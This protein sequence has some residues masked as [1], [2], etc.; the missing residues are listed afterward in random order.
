VTPCGKEPAAVAVPRAL[1]ASVAVTVVQSGDWRMKAAGGLT[2]PA[3]ASV[4]RPLR[5]SATVLSDSSAER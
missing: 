2:A 1:A 3:A 4:T 5:W